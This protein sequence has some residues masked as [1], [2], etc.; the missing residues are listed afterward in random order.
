MSLVDLPAFPV[1]ST[2]PRSVRQFLREARGRIERFRREHNV[3]AFVPGDFA[4]AYTVLRALEETGTSAGCLFCEWGSGF[5][6]TTCL[7]A[8]LGFD[9]NGIEIEAELVDEARLLARDFDLGAQFV[10]GSF[11]P[12]GGDDFAE[13]ATDCAWMSGVAGG[14]YEKLEIGPEEF[15]VVC[16][17]PWP[18]EEHLTAALFDRYAQDGAVLLTDHEVGGLRLRRRLPAVR[19]VR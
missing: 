11:I 6:V 17:Y 10:Q 7:A 1:Q 9:A 19:P 3:P 12:K 5:G 14:G 4:G 8:M 16:A 13:A 15:D 18:D 2:L